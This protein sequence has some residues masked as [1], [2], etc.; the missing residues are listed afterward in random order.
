MSEKLSAVQSDIIEQEINASFSNKIIPSAGPGG[1]SNSGMSSSNSGMSSGNNDV[2]TSSVTGPGGKGFSENK[3]SRVA[4]STEGHLKNKS[5]DTFV[6]KL[7]QKD[8]ARPAHF[9]FRF[10]PLFRNTLLNDRIQDVNF[11]CDS[12]SFPDMSVE[13]KEGKVGTDWPYSIAT[14]LNYAQFSAGFLC[15]G[16]M[17]QRVFFEDWMKLIYDGPTGQAHYYN[18]Y[19]TSVEIFQLKHNF[20]DGMNNISP[21]DQWVYKVKLNNVYP[22]TLNLQE[23]NWGNSNQYHK[24]EV[25]FH[26]TDYISEQNIGK[27]N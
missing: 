22:V 18:D 20:I 27:I 10:A 25:T 24:L 4:I 6:T 12:T 9:K 13:A 19:V 1:T 5:I 3:N 11:L 15:Q 16:D 8:L 7:R 26:F 17:M 14:G 21:D 2:T 23:L